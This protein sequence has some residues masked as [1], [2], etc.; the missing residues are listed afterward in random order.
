MIKVSQYSLYQKGGRHSRSSSIVIEKQ[1]N[2]LCRLKSQSWG[3]LVVAILTI[4]SSMF[5]HRIDEFKIFRRQQQ[6]I[7]ETKPFRGFENICYAGYCGPWIEEFFMEYFLS[8][9]VHIDRLYLPI[10]WTNCHLKCSADNLDNLRG[11]MRS[12]DVSKKYFTV[13]QIDR[14]LHH[15]ALNITLGQDLDL[16]IFSAGGITRGEKVKNIPIPLL[17]EVLSPTLQAEKTF[18]VS[19]VG[20][21]THPIRSELLDMYGHMYNFSKT[22]YWKEIIERSTFSLCPRGFGL[23]SFRLYE[24]I[25]LGSIPI[26]VW[27]GDLMLPFSD[28]LDWTLFSIIVPRNDIFMLAERIEKADTAAMSSVLKEVAGHFTYEFTSQYIFASLLV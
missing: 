11:Y 16:V 17:K 18:K 6:I 15:P 10:S 8:K 27:E 26:Y 28:I 22:E 4:A 14:G 3:L 13:L 21:M 12:L 23:T 19:F 5:R 2:L 24:A 9:K 1:L 25:Q 20:S 7:E